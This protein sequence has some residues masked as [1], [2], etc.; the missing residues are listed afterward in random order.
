LFEK[1]KNETLTVEQTVMKTGERK[2]VGFGRYN[3][4]EDFLKT[5]SALKRSGM[6][7]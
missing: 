6:I 2:I 4:E 7:S 5:S 3:S 1:P